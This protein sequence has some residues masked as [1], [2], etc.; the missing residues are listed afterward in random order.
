[1]SHQIDK[2]IVEKIQELFGEGVRNIQEMER[3]INAFVKNDIFKVESLPRQTSRQFFPER[4]DL[5]NQM[6]RASV[7]LRFSKISQEN[8]SMKVDIWRKEKVKDTFY[9]RPY[10][11]DQH[12]PCPEQLFFHENGYKISD[13]SFR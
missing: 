6:Y 13:V 4:R 9:F 5:P 2:R 11:N 12:L 7:K 1:M 3:A 8:L 10:G